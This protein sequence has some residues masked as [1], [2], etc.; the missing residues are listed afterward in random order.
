MMQSNRKSKHKSKIKITMEKSKLR[1]VWG[2]RVEPYPS[3]ATH[4]ARGGARGGGLWWM[5]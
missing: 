2:Q 1:G 5:D 3:L 4:P